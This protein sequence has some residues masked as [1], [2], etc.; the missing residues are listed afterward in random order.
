MSAV[1][2]PA[3]SALVDRALLRAVAAVL[4]RDEETEG[5]GRE[6]RAL[7][8]A[9]PEADTIPLVPCPVC[10]GE[11]VHA[12]DM[13]RRVVIEP[14]A[15]PEVVESTIDGR[16]AYSVRGTYPVGAGV[17]TE[18]AAKPEQGEPVA[19]KAQRKNKSTGEW[20]DLGGW[21]DGAPKDWVRADAEHVDEIG[22]KPY[23]LVLAYAAQPKP[24]GEAVAAYL[25]R[26]ADDR[27]TIGHNCEAECLR[28]AA[29]LVRGDARRLSG[30][31]EGGAA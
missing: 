20:A 31:A 11:A 25:D 13:L 24:A 15:K 7:L 18:T 4:E 23:R 30:Q 9:K 22:N 28:S 5:Y 17:I 3:G 6:I 14:A 2:I 29:E 16:Q 8:A 21:V 10:G 27:E 26:V 12:K 19:W 1:D